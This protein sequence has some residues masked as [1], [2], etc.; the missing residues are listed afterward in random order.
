[1]KIWMV[2][3][4][5]SPYNM[6]ERRFFERLESARLKFLSLPPH[7]KA[8]LLELEI[9]KDLITWLGRIATEKH[10][11]PER[12]WMNGVLSAT[13]IDTNHQKVKEDI[14]DIDFA[15][16]FKKHFS[17]YSE[18]LRESVEEEVLG[19]QPKQPTSPDKTMEWKC[20]D[21]PS[22]RLH[23]VEKRGDAIDQTIQILQE[24]HEKLV[25][26]HN[27]QKQRFTRLEGLFENITDRIN[28]LSSEIDRI[29]EYL[30]TIAS[31]NTQENSDCICCQEIDNPEEYDVFSG[32]IVKLVRQQGKQISRINRILEGM[33]KESDPKDMEEPG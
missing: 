27:L 17:Q 2:Q 29:N 5:D 20:K 16:P 21:D 13:L 11:D 6:K 25:G 3:Y 32:E 12:Q 28:H 10:V 1:M 22:V 33:L 7:A 24:K 14:T 30:G 9:E 4:A 18:R 19:D 31:Y 26:Q 8:D 15:E 23:M